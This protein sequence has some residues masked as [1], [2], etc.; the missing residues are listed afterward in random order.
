MKIQELLSDES[1]WCQGVM[2]LDRYGACTAPSAKDACRWCLFG[3]I[4]K[5]YS[6]AESMRIIRLVNGTL[7][8]LLET[9]NDTHT[10]PKVR[11]LIEKLDI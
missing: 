1:K 2:A 5:C 11:A 10:F 3:A 9:W 4:L 8:T 7:G 6:D